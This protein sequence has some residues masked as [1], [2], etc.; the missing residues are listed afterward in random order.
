[1]AASLPMKQLAY[2]ALASI[3]LS[4]CLK[5]TE[6]LAQ[7]TGLLPSGCGSNGARVQASVDGA[8]YCAGAQVLA[9]GDGQSVIVTGVGLTGTT[10]IIQIDSLATGTQPMTEA[11]NGLLYMENGSSFIIMPDQPGSISVTQLDTAARTIKATF[12]ATVHNEMSGG[13][14]AI[15]GSLDVQWT[16]GE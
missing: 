15:V 4:S 16:D 5:D 8:S 1:M 9:T 3:V 10:L 2:L 11:S 12:D 14:R 7:D 13:S 6:E